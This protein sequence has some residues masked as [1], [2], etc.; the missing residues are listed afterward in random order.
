ML[1]ETKYNMD[2]VPEVEPQRSLPLELPVAVLP[3]EAEA[4]P[5]V[6]SHVSAPA[7]PRSLSCIDRGSRCEEGRVPLGEQ[8]RSSGEAFSNP[9][10]LI[11][12]LSLACS[13][14]PRGMFSAPPH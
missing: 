5:P 8:I 14:L 3:S 13:P 7:H 6:E 12:K 11:R 2:A 1:L 10:P 4:R 9:G